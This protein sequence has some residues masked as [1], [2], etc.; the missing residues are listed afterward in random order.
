MRASKSRAFW[1]ILLSKANKDLDE[2]EQKSY[3]S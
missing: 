1:L 2:K 3:V